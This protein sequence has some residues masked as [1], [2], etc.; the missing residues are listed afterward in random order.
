[1]TTQ[2]SQQLSYIVNRIQSQQLKNLFLNILKVAKRFDLRDPRIRESIVKHI[3]AVR[4]DQLR[5][6]TSYDL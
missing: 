4:L 3:V 2:F 1:M 6:I 5:T